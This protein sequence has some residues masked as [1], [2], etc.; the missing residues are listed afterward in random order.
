MRPPG[1]ADGAAASL[2]NK[3]RAR[4]ALSPCCSVNRDDR[5]P[6]ISSALRG[7]TFRPTTLRRHVLAAG[8]A[9]RVVLLPRAG[10]R[11]R[12]LRRDGQ[13][14][15]RGDHVGAVHQPLAQH[16]ERRLH[17]REGPSL[18]VSVWAAIE[19][20]AVRKVAPKSWSLQVRSFQRPLLAHQTARGACCRTHLP[21]RDRYVDGFRSPA[22]PMPV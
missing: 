4:R 11:A 20:W 12:R 2:P 13:L 1:A 5:M 19:P 18:L 15:Q 6:R 3:A 8:A 21:D 14:H 7:P 10:S 22:T 16:L 9:A 17:R